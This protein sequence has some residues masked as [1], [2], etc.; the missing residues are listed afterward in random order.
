MSLANLCDIAVVGPVVGT[1]EEVTATI[2]KKIKLKSRTDAGVLK[3]S[4]AV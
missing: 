3:D 4:S 2:S 1:V